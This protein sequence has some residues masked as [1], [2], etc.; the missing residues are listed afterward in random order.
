M[1]DLEKYILANKLG[2]NFLVRIEKETDVYNPINF[3]I[4]LLVRLMFLTK[5]L[6]A[7]TLLENVEANSY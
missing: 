4:N 5:N 7:L 1:H 6:L 2:F 3:F